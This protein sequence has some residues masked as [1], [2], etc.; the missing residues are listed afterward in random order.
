MSWQITSQPASEPVT[1][2]EAR[3]QLRNEDV[4]FD[5]TFINDLITSSR[6]FCEG[7]LNR[8]LITQT[9]RQNENQWANPIKLRVNPVISVTTLKYIDS[10]EAEQTITDSTDNYQVDL[11]SD[12]ASISEG[13]VNAF[14]SLG[15]SINPIEIIMVCGYGAAADV[16][17]DIKSA[18]KLM[19]SHF[20]DNRNM[21]N[22]PLTGTTSDIP[23]PTAVY[24]LLNRYRV[25]VLG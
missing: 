11:K 9:W 22:V 23:I 15:Q 14:P 10:A 6:L 13:L 17:E 24:S 18:I 16:P 5:D 3:A 12:V 8:V 2:L 19:I 1:L 25:N 4:S 20:Y 7:Y 21:V